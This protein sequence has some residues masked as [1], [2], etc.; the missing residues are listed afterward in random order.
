[1]AHVGRDSSTNTR[2]QSA[3]AAGLTADTVPRL[4]LKWAL[5]DPDATHAW[6]QPTMAGGRLFVGSHNGT[7]YALDAA[8]GCIRWTFIAAAACGPRSRSPVTHAYFGDSNAV[9]YALDAGERPRAVAAKI[10]EHPLGRVTGSPAVH[11]GRSCADVVVRR[12]GH[13]KPAV[14]NAARFAARSRR[15]RRHRHATLA[16][17]HRRR[18]Q[19]AGHEHSGSS[20][21]GTVRRRHLGGAHHRR[22][23]RRGVCR[24]GRCQQRNRRRR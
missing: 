19:A 24:H 11:D 23:A 17:L 22:D 8:S 4:T 18:A 15:S 10:D 9:V 6:S 1:M 7:V 21:V 2:F 12:G 20:A 14:T 3:H 16:H 5:G 13:R